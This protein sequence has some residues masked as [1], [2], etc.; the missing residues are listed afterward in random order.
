ML[1]C[2]FKT[3]KAQMEFMNK[4][5]PYIEEVDFN[6]VLIDHYHFAGNYSFPLVNFPKLKSLKCGVLGGAFQCSTL[7]RLDVVKDYSNFI[8]TPNRLKQLLQSNSTLEDL[9]I[10]YE[11]LDAVFSHEPNDMSLKL[12][13]MQWRKQSDDT[14]TDSVVDNILAFLKTQKDC[15]EEFTLDWFSSGRRR[16]RRSRGIDNEFE[17]VIYNDANAGNDIGVK[18]L[19]IIFEEFKSL[20]KLVIADKRGFLINSECPTASALSLIPNPHITELRL[21]FDKTLTSDMMFEKLI[22]ACPNLKSLKVRELDQS[23]IEYCSRKLKHLEF[24]YALSFKAQTLPCKK[25]QFAKLQR[26]NFFECIIQNQ[27]E[28]RKIPLIEQK[29]KVLEMLKNE[30]KL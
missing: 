16:R 28:L 21:R 17:V 9:S 2:H 8:E 10:A 3:V 6:N 14:I 4:L 20:Q 19:G 26:L 24:L 30:K 11:V 22:T 12:K 27:P 15:L 25:I 23:L 1:N 7:E 13:K 29:Q 5:A 18:A